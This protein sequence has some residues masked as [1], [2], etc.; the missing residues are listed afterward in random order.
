M[1]G[2]LDLIDRARDDAHAIAIHLLGNPN[3]VRSNSQELRWGSH[4]KLAMTLLGSHRG[5]WRDW[6]S[7][8]H[9]DVLDL[10]EAELSLP[11][12]EA[13][14]WVKT[15]FGGTAP[16]ID[17]ATR[18][19]SQAKRETA[20]VE[21]DQQKQVRV[22]R[23]GDI[24]RASAPL[25]GSPAERYL[26]NRLYGFHI[27]DPVYEGGSL[28][29]NAA[30]RIPGSIGTMVALMTDPVTG[31]PS[32]VHRTYLDAG[33]AKIER[34][35]LGLKGVVRL[36]PDDTVT[37][38]LSI[39]EGIETALSAAVLLHAT[40]IWAALDAG[41]VAAF[42]ALNGIDAVT[43]YADND[44]EKNGRRAGQQAAIEC[45]DRWLAEGREAVIRMPREG[46]HDFNTM[47]ASLAEK[48]RAA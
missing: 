1:S 8:D 34:K 36:W 30:E 29:W 31:R 42:P 33:A 3:P 4:G 12:P 17:E 22:A 43:I 13:L 23:A 28:R 37:M 40:P 41:N 39:A 21:A 26:L 11:R 15:W 44:I 14:Q 35:M 2:A 18:A 38:G 5:K 27:P 46:D 10:I 20:G 47:L 45:A 19:K 6:S 9:G 32:G 48:G 24:W 25:E 16:A 7:D